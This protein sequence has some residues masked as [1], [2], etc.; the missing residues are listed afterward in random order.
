MIDGL[1]WVA[2]GLGEVFDEADDALVGGGV[3]EAVCDFTL[4]GVGVEVFHA[5]YGANVDSNVF[6]GGIGDHVR[7][8]NAFYEVRSVGGYIEGGDVGDTQLYSICFEGIE[9]VL[10]GN[11]CAGGDCVVCG[12]VQD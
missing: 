10:C 4:G 5:A 8:I 6:A 9:D 7:A 11:V 12:D 1:L 2:L 3:F